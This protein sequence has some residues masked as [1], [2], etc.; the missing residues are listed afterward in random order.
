MLREARI[1]DFAA[2]AQIKEAV[3]LDPEKL[4][5]PE[6]RVRLQAR[7]FLLP[8]PLIA[9]EFHDDVGQYTVFEHEGKVIGY[10]LVDDGQEL[11]AKMK[12]FWLYQG[13]QEQYLA[14]PHADL[15]G[16]SVSPETG[17]RVAW[18]G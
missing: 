10:S 6:Y 13:L 12:V 5:D 11:D 18:Q 14:K 17:R 3:M 2:I 15:R 7:G 1:S 4:A 9:D 8:L 16:I